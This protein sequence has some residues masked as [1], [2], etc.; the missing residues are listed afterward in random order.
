MSYDAIIG[1]EIHVQLK[2]KAKMFCNCDNT[3]E[4]QSPN[5]TICPICTGQPGTLPVPNEQAIRW[6]I[7]TGLALNCQIADYSKFDRKNYFYPDLPKGYQISQYDLPIAHDGWLEINGAKIEITR[8]H[9]EEDTG[10]L[11]HP[12]G[13]KY[14]LVDYNRAGTPLMELVTEP[15]IGSA[16]EAKKFCQEYQKIL[17]YLEVSDADMEKGQMR[18]EANVSIQEADKWR[19]ENGEIKPVGNYKLNPKIELKNIN[20]FRAVERAIVYEIRRQEKAL[21]E[22]GKLHQETRGW[23]EVQ[24][25]TYHQRSKEFAHDYRYFPEPDIPPL[26]LV[27]LKE[28]MKADLGELP[29]ARF[30]RFISQYEFSAEDAIILTNDKLLANYAEQVVSELKAWLVSLQEVE[31]AEKKIWKKNK[32]KLINFVSGWLI[33]KLGGLMKAKNISVSTLKITPENFA[34]FITLIYQNKINTTT[35][36]V[37]LEKM[38]KTGADPSSLLEESGLEQ[39]S[40]EKELIDIVEKIIANNPEPIAQY[41][42]GK[43]N[44]LQFLIGQVMKESRGKANPEIV[45]KILL[46]LL[47]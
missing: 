23:D 40:D 32:K 30:Q 46:E 38:L 24:G 7:L 18:C 10:K 9:L 6:T 26:N 35:A 14:S 47:T 5:T 33:N 41:K 16:Q 39:V 2:T 1:L 15:V 28:K 31:G 11:L 37:I 4:L 20:S 45:K 22:A 25:V 21:K 29:Q 13:A 19:Y 43:V 44:A 34:E 42:A 3:G 17:R 12:T 8:I 27:E 36:R